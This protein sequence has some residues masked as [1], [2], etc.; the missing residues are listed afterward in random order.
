LITW[1][2]KVSKD[3]G[4]RAHSKFSARYACSPDM[5]TVLLTLALVAM[6][7][8]A[9]A[10]QPGPTPPNWGQS[11]VSDWTCPLCYPAYQPHPTESLR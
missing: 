9:W 5:K 4:C 10:G 3:K 7:C 2:R 1:R 8:G 11:D 6:A